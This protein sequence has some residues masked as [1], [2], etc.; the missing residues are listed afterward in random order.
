MFINNAQMIILFFSVRSLC[1]TIQIYGSSTIRHYMTYTSTGSVE[2]K[3]NR[4]VL[5]NEKKFAD[6]Q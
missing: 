2:L 4:P 6:L 3:K 1:C 5:N